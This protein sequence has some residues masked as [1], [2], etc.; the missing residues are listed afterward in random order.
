MECNL[1]WNPPP[2][3]HAEWPALRSISY[4]LPKEYGI[5]SSSACL[6]GSDRHAHITLLQSIV[7]LLAIY[8]QAVGGHPLQLGQLPPDQALLTYK[9]WGAIHSNGG[10]GSYLRIKHPPQTTAFGV[11]SP[12]GV[13]LRS[14]TPGGQ[15]TPG[16]IFP[17]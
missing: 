1:L 13:M 3:R 12:E 2:N 9:L 8:I 6:I 5:P 7:C 16:G 11:R 17:P 15:L 4:S 10:R 14:E